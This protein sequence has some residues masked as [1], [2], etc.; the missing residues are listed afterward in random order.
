MLKCS[1]HRSRIWRD[2]TGGANSQRMLAACWVIQH[3]AHTA[4]LLELPQAPGRARR[5]LPAPL[6]WVFLLSDR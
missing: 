6:F 1:P 5:P 2:A 3:T 4:G